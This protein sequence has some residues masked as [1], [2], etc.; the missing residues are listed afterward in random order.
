MDLAFYDGRIDPR[1]AIVKGV[2]TADLGNAG[3]DI[4][5]D[6]ADIGAERIGHVRR[7]VV[8]HRLQPRLHAGRDLVVGGEGDLGHGLL[9][10]RHALHAE[11]V[12]VPFEIVVMYFEQIGRDHAPWP[13]FCGPPSPSLRRPRASSA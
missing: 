2:E 6:Y 8:T 9:P 11:A 13:G 7:I 3:I 5:I 4:D 10:L 12:D 1:A